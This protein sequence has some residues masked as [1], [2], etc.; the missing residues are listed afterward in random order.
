MANTNNKYNLTR[1]EMH[2]ITECELTCFDKN[3]RWMTTE[4]YEEVIKKL[5]TKA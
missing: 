1:T 3:G 5:R 2:Y 4:E